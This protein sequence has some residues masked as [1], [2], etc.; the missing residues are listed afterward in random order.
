MFYDSLFHNNHYLNALDYQNILILE[1]N[2]QKSAAKVLLFFD[3]CNISMLISNH[4]S[5]FLIYNS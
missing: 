3:I 1:Q 2:A 4:N 5:K